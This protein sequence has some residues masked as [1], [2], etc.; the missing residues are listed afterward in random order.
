MAIILGWSICTASGIVGCVEIMKH[1]GIRLLLNSG[2][3]LQFRRRE[4]S[5][6]IEII[7]CSFVQQ[8]NN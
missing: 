2:L 3:C 1:D 8:G 7:V 5:P 6:A 4:F